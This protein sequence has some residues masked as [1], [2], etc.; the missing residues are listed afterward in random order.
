[1]CPWTPTLVV[2]GAC[3]CVVRGGGGELG[4]GDI[5]MFSGLEICFFN[6]TILSL[7][8][9]FYIAYNSIYS[10]PEYF[11]QQNSVLEFF[12]EKPSRLHYKYQIVG[13]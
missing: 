3:V 7:Y 1:M 13:P 9:V 10:H 11:Y 2:C 6:C 5:K 4:G 8:S 12:S